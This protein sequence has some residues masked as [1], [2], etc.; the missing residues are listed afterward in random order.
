VKQEEEEEKVEGDPSCNLLMT[1][2]MEVCGDYRAEGCYY[3]DDPQYTRLKTLLRCWLLRMNPD[4]IPRPVWEDETEGGTE[5]EGEAEGGTEGRVVQLGEGQQKCYNVAIHLRVG[6]TL[7]YE[8]DNLFFENL[9]KTVGVALVGFECV[10]YHFLYEEEVMIEREKEKEKE[11]QRVEE[12]KKVENEKEGTE[13][14]GNEKKMR[15]LEERRWVERQPPF[16]ILT[17]IFKEEVVVVEKIV[18]AVDEKKE[19]GKEAD[20]EELMTKEEG[21][22]EADA[23]AGSANDPPRYVYPPLV[24]PPHSPSLYPRSS[25]TKRFFFPSF[26]ACVFLHRIVRKQ[27]IR[28]SYH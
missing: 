3:I 16:P 10:H 5:A 23:A 24:T 26:S 2:N 13:A 6:D 1:V 15:K 11:K 8:T 21:G 4:T 17:E 28:V 19:D 7:L 20:E 25:L 9:K 27:R 18:M 14:V 22:K 12:M